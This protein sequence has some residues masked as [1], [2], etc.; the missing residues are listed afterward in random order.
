MGPTN[1]N[2][3]ML[4]DEYMFIAWTILNLVQRKIDADQLNNEINI[5]PCSISHPKNYKSFWS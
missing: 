3:L 1:I 2:Y 4:I 5:F